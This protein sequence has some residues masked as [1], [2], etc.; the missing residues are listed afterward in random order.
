MIVRRELPGRA[1]LSPKSTSRL[2]YRSE[3]LQ[4]RIVGIGRRALREVRYHRRGSQAWRAIPPAGAAR[5][6]ASTVSLED[7]YRSLQMRVTIAPATTATIPRIAQL[8]Q[9]TNQFNLTTHRYTE[10]D[11]T[12]LAAVPD[13]RRLLPETGRLRRQQWDCRGDD[14]TS[15][16]G[17]C[18][19]DRHV[20]DELPGDGP[21]GG[22]R[23]PRLHHSYLAAVGRPQAIGQIPPHRQKCARRRALPGMRVPTSRRTPPVSSGS[24]I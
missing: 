13:L 22:R 10:A 17:R 5:H 23:L 19:D 7:F 8:T 21:D 12:T 11:I 9:K 18:L 4:R 3:R 14:P 1:R 15:L 16:P 2:A 6:A 20:F 24:W